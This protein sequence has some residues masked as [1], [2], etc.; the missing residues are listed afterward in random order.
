MSNLIILVHLPFMDFP[1]HAFIKRYAGPIRAWWK[2]RIA[3]LIDSSNE[4]GARA[5]YQEFYLGDLPRLPER[6]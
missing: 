4:E 6:Y 5:L 2:S 3:L 1:S